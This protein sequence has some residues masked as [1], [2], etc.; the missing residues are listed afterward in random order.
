MILAQTVQ[1]NRGRITKLQPS[2]RVKCTNTNL[3]VIKMNNIPHILPT[4][5]P[6]SFPLPS[7][8]SII[9]PESEITDNNSVIDMK[10]KK[11]VR[12]Y[13]PNYR[14]RKRKGGFL[15]R[16][17]STDGRKLLARRRAKGRWR[18]GL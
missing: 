12:T 13:Q 10:G 8:V 4:R 9:L 3:P 1:K 5:V 6:H 11:G 16:L 7:N 14:K 2:T 15:V 18:L 17:K